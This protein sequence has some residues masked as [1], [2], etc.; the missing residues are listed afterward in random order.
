MA[1]PTKETLIGMRKQYQRVY[2]LDSGLAVARSQVPECKTLDKF[3]R[4]TGST[5]GEVWDGGGAYGGFIATAETMSIAS[6]SVEDASA[7]TGARTVTVYGLDSNYDELSETVTMD[8][9]TDASLTGE[10]I[11]I[12]RALVATAGSVGTNV[13][14]ITITSDTGAA[15]MAKISAGYGQT[16]MAVYT[17][18]RNYNLYMLHSAISM[19]DTTKSLDARFVGRPFGGAWNTKRTV[20]L[21]GGSFD[22]ELHH[23]PLT[24]P[25]KTDVKIYFEVDVATTVSAA[26]S[27]IL[28]KIG[29]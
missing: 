8:G 7:A 10:Y 25:E 6:T 23:S 24:M 9:D 1:A 11:R 28:E 14:D 19:A 12:F 3:G 4:V 27:G 21:K 15:V 16:L 2:T 17:V 22:G 29:E 26:F 13:G 5:G 18:P 20:E